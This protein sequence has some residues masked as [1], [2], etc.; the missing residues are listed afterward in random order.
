MGRA[1]NGFYRVKGSAVFENSSFRHSRFTAEVDCHVLFTVR[2]LDR[3]P[4][5]KNCPET[6]RGAILFR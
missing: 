4:R 5:R 2:Q 6:G 1:N 3:Y